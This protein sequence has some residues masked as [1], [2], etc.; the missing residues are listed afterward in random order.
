LA[1][2]CAQKAV[3]IPQQSGETAHQGW[4]YGKNL[5]PSS[6]K[7]QGRRKIF[8]AGLKLVWTAHGEGKKIAERLANE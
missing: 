7:W 4:G 8:M 1:K 5:L 3:K 6:E 2:P